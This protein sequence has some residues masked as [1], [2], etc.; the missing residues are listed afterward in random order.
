MTPQTRTRGAIPYPGRQVSAL[1][2]PGLDDHAMLVDRLDPSGA[3]CRGVELGRHDDEQPVLIFALHELLDRLSAFVARAQRS[4]PHLENPPPGEQRQ[5]VGVRDELAP[6]ETTLHRIEIPL[7]EPLMPGARS[8][9]L[10]RLGHDERFVSRD[11]RH[12]REIS[13]KVGVEFLRG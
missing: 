7:L 2:G 1:Y 10:E 3:A 4:E 5:R 13:A 12:R 6:T 9:G 11:Q 8:N